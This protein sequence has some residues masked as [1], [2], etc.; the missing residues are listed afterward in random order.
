MWGRHRPQ[1]RHRRGRTGGRWRVL[2]THEGFFFFLGWGRGDRYDPGSAGGGGIRPLLGSP[3]VIWGG[4][5]LPRSPPSSAA[6]WGSRGSR[7]SSRLGLKA[8]LVPSE[9]SP[10]VRQQRGG[11]SGSQTGAIPS[12]VTRGEPGGSERGAF[13][14]AASKFASCG[15][16]QL[17]GTPIIMAA[18][19]SNSI[20]LHQVPVI[21]SHHLMRVF[22]EGSLCR[23]RALRGE[24]F[25]EGL[26]L[27]TLARSLGGRVCLD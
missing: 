27:R 6:A 24:F 12:G 16:T 17:R 10:G 22:V 7:G 11:S 8:P 4:S 25:G 26:S 19:K 9:T 14:E 3:L 18:I 20:H 13:R 15:L 1:G 2:G 5:G 21:W 23:M